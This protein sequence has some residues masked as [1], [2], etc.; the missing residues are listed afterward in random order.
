MPTPNHPSNHP[1]VSRRRPIGV[2]L[3]IIILSVA[4]LLVLDHRSPPSLDRA[5]QTSP[6]VLDASDRILRSFTVAPGIWRLPASASDVDPLYLTMLLAYED[7]RFLDHPG[8]DPLAVIRA[9]GQWLRHG[10]IVSGASTLTMQAARLLEPHERDLSG[11]L[12]EMLRALQLERR[13]SK[14]EI[15]SFYLTLAPYGGNLEGI[16]AASLVWLGKEPSRLTAAEAALLVALPQAPSRVRPDRSPERARAARD[17]VLAR[18]EQLGVLTARQVMEA[19]QEPLPNQRR[20]LP[21]L[22]PHLADRLQAAQPETAIHRTFIDRDLQ[23]ILETLAR[24]QHSTLESHSSI[25]IL[26]VAHRSR[27]VLAYVGGSDFHDPRRAGQVDLIRAVRSPGSTL[28]PLIYALGFDDLLIHPETLIEDVPTRF[29]DYSPT[30]F[31]HTYA[32]QLTVREALQQSLNIP[33]VAILEQVGPARVAARLRQAGL[34]LHWNAAHPQPGLP[35][36]LGGVGMTLEELVTLYASFAED[37]RVTPLRFGP[38]DPERP[39]QSL[40]SATACWYLG[41]I[42]RSSPIPQNVA[43]P[44]SAAQPR[45][46]AHKTGTSYG[47]RDAW[48]LGFDTDYTVGVWVG[49]PDGSPSPGHYGR[50]TAAPLLFRVFDLLPKPVNPL[51]APPANALRV[52]SREQLPERLRYFRTRPAV[53]TVNA[54]PLDITFPV[55]GTTVELP[56]ADGAWAELPLAAKG[57]VRPLRWLVNGQP[58]VVDPWRREAFWPPDGEGLARI[59]VLDQAGQTASAEVWIRRSGASR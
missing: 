48:A 15:L 36:A 7:Q 29:G 16:R 24:Q 2:G 56:G 40:L 33:A 10:R 19:R 47:F 41:E 28:K 13:Y 26:V 52:V 42:L 38:A 37:G 12:G 23:R 14:A 9:L 5:R 17:K 58:L 55:A 27:Q 22:A 57:G 39:G 53:E 1:P 32:G 44:P 51:T 59:T 46:I 49:R 20:A 3:A 45:W 35:L 6:L 34:P 31:R 50:N 54:P 4:V 11:K 18:M 25:A 43:P 30:N 8:I 21:F